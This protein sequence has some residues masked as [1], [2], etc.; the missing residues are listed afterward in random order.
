MN[1][2]N[3]AK[4]YGIVYRQRKGKEFVSRRIVAIQLRIAAPMKESNAI[5]SFNNSI[6]VI[7]TCPPS[8]GYILT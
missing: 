4:V 8:I 2:R 6:L 5:S 1:I 7:N 3:E